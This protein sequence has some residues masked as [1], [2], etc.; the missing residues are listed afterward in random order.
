MWF[1]DLLTLVY[2]MKAIQKRVVRTNLVIYICI[3]CKTQGLGNKYIKKN[4][5]VTFFVL[6]AH[7]KKIFKHEKLTHN[8]SNEGNK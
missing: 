8:T 6:R 2:L 5:F 4:S 7:V 1:S 3:P